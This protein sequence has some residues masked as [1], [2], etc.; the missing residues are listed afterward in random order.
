MQTVLIFL[1]VLGIV[2]VVHELGH[3][4]VAKLAGVRVLEFGLGYPPRLFGFRRGETVYSLNLLPLGGFVRFVGEEDPTDPG[5]LAGRA[6]WV[7]L[8]VLAAGPAMNIVLP[9]LLF[10]VL[11]MAPRSVLVTDVVIG[12][13]APDSPAALA[14]LQPGD[15]VREVDGRTIDN[16][17]DLLTAVQL[18]LGARTQWI[19]QRGDGLF[20]TH[21]VPRVDPPEGQAA[22]G[23]S[24]IVDARITVAGVAGGST[25]QAMG[26]IAGDLLLGMDNRRV[27]LEEHVALAVEA[28]RA[29]DPAAAVPVTVL[30]RGGIVELELP[31]GSRELTGMEL[32]VRPEER[33]SQPIWR[34]LPSSFVQMKDILV[35]SKNELSR[36][37]SGSSTTSPVAGPIGI[38][39]LTG[40]VARAGLSALVFWTA[41]LSMSLAIL[42]ILPIPA[43]DGGRISFVLLELA[44]GGRRIPPKKE[45]LVH[46]VGFAVLMALIVVVSIND[47]QRILGGGSLIN[48]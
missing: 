23:L 14:R 38:A 43:L 37:I 15:I 42:N 39:Q 35:I 27:L 41:L 25:A 31:A 17:T 26:L 47:I 19:V 16:S 3:F 24:S 48:P 4:S 28:A 46:L 36:W 1:T 34:A 18:N 8:A 2:V 21:L 20:E 29:G 11:F 33:R 7:R 5:S 6:A 44:R 30:R 13:V 40:E 9:L 22:V 12:G 45:A 32:V 10:T